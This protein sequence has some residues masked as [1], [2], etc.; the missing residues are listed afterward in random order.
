[1]PLSQ[2]A[3]DQLLQYGF[4]T[5]GLVRPTTWYAAIFSD[6][7]GD[8]GTSIAN[9][10]TGTGYAR[11]AATLALSV[12]LVTNTNVVTFTAGGT[13]PA[14]TYAGVCDAATGGTLWAYQEMGASG[15]TFFLAACQP[16]T[17]GSGYL[18]GDAL[19]V[20]SGGGAVITVDAV[21]T[22]GGVAGVITH[23][24][25][26]AGGAVSSALTGPMAT[27]GGT[28][29]GASFLGTWLV[30]PTSYQLNSSDSLTFAIGQIQ[31]GIG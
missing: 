29:S 14:A 19:V 3:R 16:V 9:E 21:A 31:F 8:A 2:Y 26:S 4:T 10:I 28:G 24:H 25:V 13:W 18:A 1:M 20:S 15:G 11:Q 7:P 27:S 23:W 6:F 30:T 22:V 12:H 5:A 17:A